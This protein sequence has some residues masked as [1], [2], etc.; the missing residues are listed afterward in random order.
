LLAASVILRCFQ[1][2]GADIP[3]VT[4]RPVAPVGGLT[5]VPVGR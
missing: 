1:D 4:R 3:L 5:F 2:G